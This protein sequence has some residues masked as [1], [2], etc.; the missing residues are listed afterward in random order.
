MTAS[1][2]MGTPV[3]PLPARSLGQQPRWRTLKKLAAVSGQCPPWRAANYE[4]TLKDISSTLRLPPTAPMPA[5][6]EYAG[7]CEAPQLLLDI[8]TDT[9]FLLKAGDSGRA[10]IADCLSGGR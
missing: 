5:L 3:L 4:S 6:F 10:A 7:M 2:W 8:Q 9:L 1:L